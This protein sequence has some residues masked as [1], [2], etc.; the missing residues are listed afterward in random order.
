MEFNKIK[1]ILSNKCASAIGRQHVEGLEPSVYE[2]DVNRSLMQTSDAELFIIHNGSPPLG[3]INDI[4]GI[5]KRVELDAI[6]NPSELLQVA[7]VLR[8]VR[9]MKRYGR[10]SGSDRPGAG[11]AT[12]ESDKKAASDAVNTSAG[13]INPGTDK[14]SASDAVNTS[15]GAS[16]PKSGSEGA[17]NSYAFPATPLEGPDGV[18]SM[19][20]SLVEN[21]RLENNIN[22]CILNEEELADD[23][24]PAL[25][26]IR[27]NVKRIQDSIK[28]KL[29]SLLRSPVYQK[30]MQDSLVTMR[31]DRYVIPVKQEHRAEI[32]GLVHDMSASGATVFVEPMAVVEAN[33]EIRELKVK[34]AVEI[35]RI[36]AELTAE[37]GEMGGDLSGDV[38]TLGLLDFLFA[39]AKLSLDYDCTRPAIGAHEKIHIKKG[40]HPLLRRESVVPIDF[41]MADGVTTVIITGPNTGGKTVA[42][43][44][45]GLLTLM[46]Q[47]GL[48][49]PANS[50]SSLRLFNKVFADIGDE[51]SIEQ[52]LST[53]SSHMRNIVRIMRDADE[54]TLALFDEI[55]AGTD[56][57]EGAAI[58]TA[59]LE[60]LHQTGAAT[61]ATTHYSEL[62]LYALT[63]PGVENACCEF[64]VNTLRPTYKLLIGLP[65]K[66]NAFAI[67]GRLGLAPEILDRAREF[68]KDDNVEFEDVLHAI[69]KNK[70]ESELER[71]AAEQA[72][73]EIEGLRNDLERQ[74][75]LMEKQKEDIMREAR[76]DARRV[77]FE[78]RHEAEEILKNLRKLEDEEDAELRRKGAR[79][80]RN[81]LNTKLGK[82]ESTLSF[83]LPPR[84]GYVEPPKNLKPGDTV[85]IVNLNQRGVVQKTPDQHG[86]ALIQVGIMSIT[87]HVSNIRVVDEQRDISANAYNAVNAANA[88]AGSGE[89]GPGYTSRSMNAR[90]EIDLRGARLEDAIA[91]VDRYLD[92]TTSSGLNEVTIIHGKGTGALR[93]GIQDFLRGHPKAR[94]FRNGSYGEGDMGVTIV[95][96][97]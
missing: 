40:R 10:S 29:N 89:A 90:S 83:K 62:K 24:S 76:E 6:L 12:Q 39:K 86:D 48:H 64:D 73:L 19:I 97:K 28:D 58:A 96:L 68:L 78:S 17:G 14:K 9:G 26:S 51:Q 13:T 88:A 21:Q 46:A 33:N 34:E 67:S 59:I 30:F 54:G 95:T 71:R 65:G 52:S 53:F 16:A 5:I 85:E 74:R 56:P 45:V 35:E 4:R 44:T 25:L 31:H 27:R 82:M 1:D 37:V 47:A 80:L 42:L 94:A 15:A 70:E 75:V 50:G 2:W 18:V 8:A 60:C 23:A 91:K 84:E 20:M 81:K 69:G 49:I 66:S 72:R 3:G 36:L 93:A 32:K 11:S 57:T 41:W 87:A 55:G 22:A 61:V 63:T 43:K 77:L 7:S 92:E 38:E 79:E